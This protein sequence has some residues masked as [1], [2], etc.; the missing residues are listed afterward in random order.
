MTDETNHCLKFEQLTLDAAEGL[1]LTSAQKDFLASHRTGIGFI[2]G[3][4][5]GMEH[6]VPGTDIG[7]GFPVF[8]IL[9]E[10]VKFFSL[11]ICDI[12]TVVPPGFSRGHLDGGH[13]M[14]DGAQQPFLG[15]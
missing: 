1:T 14:V 15:S 13:G 7:N 6:T 9:Y 8:V 3:R 11:G 5:K 12:C 2:V 4:C 10:C